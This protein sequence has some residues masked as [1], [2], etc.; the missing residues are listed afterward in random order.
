MGTNSAI[1]YDVDI[2]PHKRGRFIAGG[3]QRIVP[4][5]FLRD[6]QPSLVVAMNPVYVTEIGA[7]LDAM[8][9]RAHLV[10]V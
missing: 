5:D 3:G 9:V 4:P 1:R 2:N 6:Y 8:G 10:A 7:A